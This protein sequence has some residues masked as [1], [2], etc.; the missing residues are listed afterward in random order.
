MYSNTQRWHLNLIT[1]VHKTI[2]LQRRRSRQFEQTLSPDKVQEQLLNRAGAKINWSTNY[3]T[4]LS[5]GSSQGSSGCEQ[6]LNSYS[7][8]GGQHTARALGRLHL[9][10]LRKYTCSAVNGLAVG[11]RWTSPDICDRGGKWR[12]AGM[13]H[14]HAWATFTSFEELEVTYGKPF[15]K[16]LQVRSYY[17]RLYKKMFRL[18]GAG[19]LSL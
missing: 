15:S 3:K 18:W 1:T 12:W 17:W 4:C 13:K 19:V 14:E 9:L 11:H 5:G 10:E 2:S 6:V 8:L 16:H 7:R